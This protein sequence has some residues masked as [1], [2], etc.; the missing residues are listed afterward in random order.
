[1]DLISPGYTLNYYN[2]ESIFFY[3]HDDYSTV[4]LAEGVNVSTY[5]HWGWRGDF[6]ESVFESIDP[7]LSVDFFQQFNWNGSHIDVYCVAPSLFDG[8]SVVGMALDWGNY[9]DVLW[10][11]QYDLNFDQNTIIHEI[12]HA[13][14]LG[15]PDGDGYSELYN[16]N[17]TVM[18]Y[19]SGPDGW[20][21]WFS[22]H[23]I[24]ALQAIWGVEQNVIHGGSTDD[25]IYSDANIKTED[26]FYG[27]SGDDILVGFRG[28]DDMWG[29][30]G[31]DVIRA[32]NGRD[33]IWGDSGSDTLFGG[34]GRNTFLWENDGAVD[35]LY[36]KS[37]Q[38]AYN[39]IYESAGNS[40]NGEKSDV[41]YELDSFDRIHVQGVST[42]D[43]SFDT[44]AGGIGIFANGT[45]EATYIGSNL[46]E[47]QI[48]QMTFG[49]LA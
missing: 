46:N 47:D 10:E 48:S 11:P 6:V 27:Y 36:L 44:V 9:Y 31:N 34:F 49:A 20:R 32:G 4:E 29:D 12:G 35:D 37:D 13:L 19:N 15:H 45:L 26:F 14:G 3:V 38:Y 7:H 2:S 41:I 22:D 24:S 25:A 42:D 39:W 40:P 43:L 28:A 30:S 33:E 8:T 17:D 16:Q 21:T 5:S 1:M 18:S 23:D